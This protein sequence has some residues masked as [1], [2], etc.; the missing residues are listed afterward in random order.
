MCNLKTP[1]TFLVLGTQNNATMG[2]TGT[3]ICL[4]IIACAL[5]L[6]SPEVIFFIALVV[7]M[8]AE[9]I[10]VSDALSGFSNDATIT[11]GALFLIVHAIEKSNILDII[12]RN[13]FGFGN[14]QVISRARMYTTCVSLSAF[15]N[16]TPLVA[17]MMPGLQPLPPKNKKM[18]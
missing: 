17:L 14:I 1:L 3:V 5:E 12:A 11:I 18:L 4:V 9:V 8:L 6:S 2:L 15:F 7:V 10:S 13:A 16:N